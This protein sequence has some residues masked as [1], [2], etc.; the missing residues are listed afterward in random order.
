MGEGD[1]QTDKLR[2]RRARIRKRTQN[3]IVNFST[4]VSR[5]LR[6]LQIANTN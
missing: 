1:I 4:S 2:E 6:N 5:R 3:I